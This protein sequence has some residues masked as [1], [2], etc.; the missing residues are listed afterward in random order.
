[1]TK[2]WEPLTDLQWGTISPFFELQRKRKH[3]LQ[4][5]MDA[6]LW[7]LRTGTQWRNLPPNFP[8]WQ[9]VYRAGG[10]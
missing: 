5:V 8:P 9:A 4:Q 3:N 2:Q 7:L 10:P 6:I 1:M